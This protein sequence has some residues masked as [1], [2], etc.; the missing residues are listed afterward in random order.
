M[1]NKTCGNCK[2]RCYGVHYGGLMN[3][4]FCILNKN[5]YLEEKFENYNENKNGCEKFV[6]GVNQFYGKPSTK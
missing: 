3:K 5:I 4:Q 6:K 2:A 1:E